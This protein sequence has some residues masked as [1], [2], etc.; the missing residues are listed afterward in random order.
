[1]PIIVNRNHFNLMLIDFEKNAFILIDPAISI[2][3]QASKYLTK[4][5]K[6]ICKIYNPCHENKI[7]CENLTAATLRHLKQTIVV[8]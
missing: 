3:K 1:M 8:H 2:E 5:K 6:F 4:F 7:N